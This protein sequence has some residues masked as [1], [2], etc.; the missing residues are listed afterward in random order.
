MKLLKIKDR[1]VFQCTYQEKDIPKN[2]GFKWDKTLRHW[3]TFDVHIANKLVSYS[4]EITLNNINFDL[5]LKEDSLNNSQLSNSDIDVPHNDG[6]NYLPYQKAGIKYALDHGN[7]LI[8]DEMGLG[9][10]IQAIGYINAKNDIKSVLIV[11]P[12]SLKINWKRELEKWLVNKYTIDIVYDEFPMS[13]IVICSYNILKT[14]HEQLISRVWDL[15]ILDE[16]HYLKNNKTLRTKH[17]FGYRNNIPGKEEN[18]VPIKSNITLSLTGT[19]ILNRPSELWPLLRHMDNKT[20]S[21]WTYYVERYCAAK[22]T[23]YGWDTRGSSNEE[24][25]QI[26]LRETIMVRRLKKDVLKEL[27][28]KRRATIIL[29]SDEVRDVLYNESDRYEKIKDRLYKLKLFVEDCKS[30]PGKENL[31]KEA[32]E[33]LNK[34]YFASF[35]EISKICHETALVKTDYAID[36]IENFM[37]SV[38]KVVIFA[39]HHDVIDKLYEGL[40]IFNPVKVVGGMSDS[41]KQSSV[42]S[43]QNDVN[44]KI[45]IGSITAAGVGYTL[46]ASSNVIF[47]ELNWV[48]GIM[49]QAEDRCHRIGTINSVLCQYLVLENSIDEKMANELISKQDIIDKCLDSK[50]S[51]EKISLF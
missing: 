29:P 11:C 12:A 13:D 19:P 8:A 15:K 10:T 30:I 3:Y 1:Y 23:R 47:I 37:E 46:T 35:E 24:E 4:D 48:P 41:E 5:R 51:S 39:H 18:I 40:K 49:S 22:H 6:L 34:E 31:Y 44:T 20:W 7:T 17:V 9:K 36:Y 50:M 32:I 14:F 27:P 43:F 38:D 16:A 45:F 33:S 28:P 42:D 2:I 26:K 25:L 21:N